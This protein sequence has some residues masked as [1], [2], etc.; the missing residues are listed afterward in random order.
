[1][2]DMMMSNVM[3]GRCGIKGLRD[4]SMPPAKAGD[5]IKAMK[6]IMEKV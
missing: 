6:V 5:K 4:F 3:M 1:M 2:S